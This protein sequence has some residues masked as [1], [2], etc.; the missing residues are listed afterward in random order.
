MGVSGR[1]VCPWLLKGGISSKTKGALLGGG[2]GRPVGLG[3]YLSVLLT[4]RA[5]KRCWIPGI[6]LNALQ[7]SL[8]VEMLVSEHTTGAC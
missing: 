7:R 1:D 8:W 2:A 3:S 5:D 4:C 6:S